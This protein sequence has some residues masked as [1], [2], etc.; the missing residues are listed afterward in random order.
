MIAFDL[1]A[2]MQAGPVVIAEGGVNH[3]GD[4]GLAHRLVD[5][6]AA[7]GAH[8]IKFQ[9]FQP[10][11]LVASGTAS[12]PY[13]VARSGVHDQKALL[14]SLA[15]PESA[16][17][18]LRQH[19]HQ[20]GLGFVS[21]PFD[22]ASARLLASVGVDAVKISSGDVTFLSFLRQ[23][24]NLG[25]P[26]LVSTGTASLDEV[27][28]AWDACEAAPFRALF[29]CVT[30]YPA[31]VTEANLKAIQQLTEELGGAWVGWSDHTLGHNSAVVAAA[32]GARLFEKHLTLDRGMEGPDHAASLE[33]EAFAE[34][35]RLILSVPDMLGD[36]HKRRMPSEEANARLVRRSWHAA[37]SL[38]AGER[39]G[40]QDLEALRPEAG[41]PVSRELVGYRLRRAVA[42]GEPLTEALVEPPD[43]GVEW[44]G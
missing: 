19:A 29:H 25:L 36:G 15:L 7:S 41:I 10:S 24:S 2:R 16:W 31:P 11:S 37:R 35:V 12:T 32:L 17:A 3:N 27:R 4:L 28:A 26:M 20:A 39:L 8:I 43:R 18:D 23:V 1:E 34:Y 6:A 21:T 42:A 5:A 38:R 13:Q 22:E 40:P 9:T 33:P 30:A 14:E 44:P